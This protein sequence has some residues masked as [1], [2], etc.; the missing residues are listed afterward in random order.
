MNAKVRIN[1]NGYVSK[2]SINDV[3]NL[4]KAGNIAYF[5]E[6]LCNILS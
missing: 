6:M 5:Q 1:K 4:L 2:K 3:L